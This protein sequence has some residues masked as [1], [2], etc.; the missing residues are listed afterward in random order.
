DL[1]PGEDDDVKDL[2]E[3]EGRDREVD[4]AQAGRKVGDEDGRA[5]GGDEAVEHGQPEARRCYR[6]KRGGRA[7]HAEAE[8]R[9]VPERDHAGV[10]D[11]D[12]GGHRQEP[13]DQDRRGKALPE[14]REHERGGDQQDA[15]DG[16]PE[17]VA[18]GGWRGPRGRPGG[19]L[20]VGTKSPVGRK[21]I[22]RTSTTNETITAWAGLTTIA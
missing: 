1:R 14:R 17:P 6:K 10:A 8:E 2:R 19:H 13:P 3:D 20:G 5:A 16:E 22:V 4:V 15:H 9:R 11:E 7:V 21:S 18:D 12:V